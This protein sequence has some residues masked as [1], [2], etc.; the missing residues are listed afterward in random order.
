MNCHGRV[1]LLAFVL[2]ACCIQAQPLISPKGIVSSATYGPPLLPGGAIAQGSIF[3][4]FGSGMG[5]ATA[6]QVAVFPLQVALGGVSLKVIQGST[7]VDA[8]PL[9][10]SDGVINAIMPSNAPTG[11]VSVQVTFNGVKGNMAPVMVAKN[12]P[13]I[14]TSTGAG[15][16]A[17]SIQNFVSATVQPL[18]SAKVTAK[19]GQAEI[20]WLTGLGPVTT[21]DNVAPT[22]ATLPYQTEVWVGGIA[23]SVQYSGRTGC[24]AGVDEIVFT[25][26]SNAPN[27]CF[28]PVQV[29]VAGTAVSNAVT[30]A[31]DSQGGACSDAANTL[32]ATYTRGGNLGAVMLIRRMFHVDAGDEPVVD[33]TVDQA[34]G[35]FQKASGAD[36]AFNPSAAL[37]PAGSCTVYSQKG[38]L[39]ESAVPFITDAGILDAGA[40]SVTGPKATLPLVL[41]KATDHQ[42]Y[43]AQFGSTGLLPA[44]LTQSPLFL[45]P[46]TFQI[47]GAGG[48]NVGAF[49]ASVTVDAG[50]T[51]TNRDQITTIDRTKGLTVTWSG[52]PANVAVSGMGTDLPTDSSTGFLCMAPAGTTSFTVPA[53]VLANVPPTRANDNESRSVVALLSATAPVKFTATGLDNSAAFFMLMSAKAVTFQ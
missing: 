33:V 10:A 15:V 31:I 29:R 22:V 16:G 6:A 44:G 38:D 5:P 45:D 13:A 53:Y 4:I 36:Y 12:A 46:G 7:S 32:S 19:Q 39:S 23:A 1:R 26:P 8:I 40:I 42:T 11:L 47:K 3:S 48:T 25:V 24:C 14:Y 30:M 20:L 2:V 27:G 18:N 50:A 52:T 49:T 9:Y 28:V 17:G 34:M 37:P 35:N 51:W 43:A 41:F 21:A